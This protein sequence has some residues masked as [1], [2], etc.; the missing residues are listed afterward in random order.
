MFAY[1]VRCRTFEILISMHKLPASHQQNG[2]DPE[3]L[4]LLAEETHREQAVPGY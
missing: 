4:D 2:C 1:Y 3:N